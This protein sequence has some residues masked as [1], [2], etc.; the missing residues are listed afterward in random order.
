MKEVSA[1]LARMFLLAII[2][3]IIALSLLWYIANSISQPITKTALMLKDISQGEGD[4]T[5]RIESD[6]EDEVG[7]LARHFNLFVE[8]I[9]AIISQVKRSTAHLSIA[10]EEISSS[11]QKIADGAQQQ[12]ASFEELSSS[13]QANAE[14]A[15]SANELSMDSTLKANKAE[16]GMAQTI[17]AMTE[18]EKSSTQISEA[19]RL[20]TDIA[21][22]TNLLALNAA[23]EAAR[24]GEHGKGFAVVADEV[25]QLA[26]KSSI[27]AKEIKNLAK[28][29]L[30][31]IQ[32]GVAISNEAGENVKAIITNIRTIAKQLK[33]ISQATQE[34]SSSMEEN[35]AI[36]QANASG[37][38]ELSAT[39]EEMASQAENLQ[40]LV[41]QFKV[42]DLLLNNAAGKKNHIKEHSPEI[43]KPQNAPGPKQGKNESEGLRIG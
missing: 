36:T 14:N 19:V 8:K 20:I 29:S 12:A 42:S 25:R 27:S 30:T 7:R 21:D 16:S 24:A 18:I 31:Q 2:A 10:T 43:P 40:K 3:T 39:T 35:S 37:T 28:G 9:D 38:E 4:L 41:E 33:M 32:D 15:I 13:I 17:D 11:T 23:I 1:S 6:S 26:E 34:Q 22:Q 5:K